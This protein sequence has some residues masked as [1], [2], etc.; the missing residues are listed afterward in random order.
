MSQVVLPA[1][2]IAA[3]PPLIVADDGY[4]LAGNA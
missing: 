1:E 2:K 3:E 4:R